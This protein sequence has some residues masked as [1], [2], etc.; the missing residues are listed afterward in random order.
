MVRT[1][2]RICAKR[3]RKDDYRRSTRWGIYGSWRERELRGR[4]VGDVCASGVLLVS[5]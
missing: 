5:L 4:F 3:S 1:C 2:E